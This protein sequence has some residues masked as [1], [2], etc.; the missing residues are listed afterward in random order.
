MTFAIIVL[1]SIPGLVHKHEDVFRLWL[2]FDFP[3]Y[4]SQLP[5]HIEKVKIADLFI[6]G[7]DCGLVEVEMHVLG[8]IGLYVEG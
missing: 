2:I 3:F 7:R 4:F 6:L 5:L 1:D 8:I